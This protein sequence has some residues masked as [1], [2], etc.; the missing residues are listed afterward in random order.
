[1]KRAFG[2]A[3]VLALTIGAMYL[4]QRRNRHDAVSA[5]A[6]VNLAADWQR[7]LTRVPMHLTRISDS[8]EMR[9][10]DQLA[11]RYATPIRTAEDRALERYI[12]EVGQQVTLHARRKLIWHFHLLADPSLINAF[13]LPG[14]HIFVGSGLLDQL[15]SEDELAFVLG[16]EIEHVDHY[17]AAERVQIEAKLRHVDLDLA[18]QL[19]SIPMSLWQAGYSKDEESEADREGLRIAVASDYSSQGAVNLLE[20]WVQL[21][22]EYVI[23]AE[24]PTDELGQV[25]IEGLTGYFRSHPLPSERLAQAKEIIEQEHLATGKPLKP[26][27]LAY[28]ITIEAK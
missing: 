21:H 12:S 27:H 5:S 24:T 26:F 22:R 23:H 6:L 14:G 2:L 13:A 25:A 28:E 3:A 8:E 17:H 15:K 4:A 11:Q 20:R 19:L 18:G 7:D 16:H 1:M 10:G 9:I